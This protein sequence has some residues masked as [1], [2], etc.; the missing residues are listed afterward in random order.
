MFAGSR[1]AA[2]LPEKTTCTRPATPAIPSGRR[3]AVSPGLGWRSLSN[4]H[5]RQTPVA[6]SSSGI[7][8]RPGCIS[9]KIFAGIFDM[10][11][12]PNPLPAWVCFPDWRRG[13]A[14]RIPAGENRAGFSH[15]GARQRPASYLTRER[16]Y[17]PERKPETT[18]PPPISAAL[19]CPQHPRPVSETTKTFT[20]RKC[21][22]VPCACS[23]T[24][25]DFCMKK[26]ASVITCR[27]W[28]FSL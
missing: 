27:I 14:T 17:L 7:I 15:P 16:N 20:C 25:T 12:R 8:Y 5:I 21:L 28:L 9:P 6:G 18:R 22:P 24:G 3:N 23:G 13:T 11:A 10:T 1:C 26:W 4:R 2:T 19:F